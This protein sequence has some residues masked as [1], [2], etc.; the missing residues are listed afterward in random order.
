MM[1]YTLYEEAFRFFNIGLAA[2]IAV[3]FLAFVAGLSILKVRVFDRSV[4]HV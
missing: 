2:A 4:P 1:L 3:T